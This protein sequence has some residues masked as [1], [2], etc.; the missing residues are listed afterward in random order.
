VSRIK[1][2][3]LGLMLAGTVWSFDGIL[4][5]PWRSLL[6]TITVMVIAMATGF[7]KKASP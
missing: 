2:L 3:A 4:A 6:M 7:L 5:N 1:A